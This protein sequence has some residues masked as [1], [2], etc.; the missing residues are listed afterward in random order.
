MKAAEAEQKLLRDRQE[1]YEFQKKIDDARAAVD[2]PGIS[3]KELDADLKR[4][5]P[6]AVRLRLYDNARA[7][8]P[9]LSTAATNCARWRR[10]S[11]PVWLREK[12]REA[13][14]SWVVVRIEARGA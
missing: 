10:K 9:A 4:D 5:M 3:A 1:F 7:E 6:E 13:L 12:G 11:V 2:K 14:V 8:L